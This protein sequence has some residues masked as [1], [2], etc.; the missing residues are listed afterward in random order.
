M[1]VSSSIGYRSGFLNLPPR[2]QLRMIDSMM[3]S[4]PT[5]ART[6]DQNYSGVFPIHFDDTTTLIFSGSDSRSLSRGDV[7]DYNVVYP[8][9]TPAHYPFSA[10][11]NN[12]LGTSLMVATP[13]VTSSISLTRGLVSGISEQLV[14][15]NTDNT[16]SQAL[17]PFVDSRVYLGDESFYLTG[18]DSTIL[19]GFSSRLANKIQI[20]INLDPAEETSVFFST[21]TAPNAVGIQQGVNSGLAYFN[22]NV[23]R[24]EVIGDLTTGSNVDY[25]NRRQSLRT[26]SY[27]AFP[28]GMA[29]NQFTQGLM[30]AV[31]GVS[32]APSNVAGFP[33]SSKFDATGSQLLRMSNYINH[34]FLMEKAV[35][36]WTGS[37]NMSSSGDPTTFPQVSSFFILNQFGTPVDR[38][39]YTGK[40]YYAEIEGGLH[41]VVG[42]NGPF[43]VSREKDLVAYG[44]IVKSELPAAE[45]AQNQKRDLVLFGTNAGVTGTFRLPM[46]ASVPGIYPHALMGT[47]TRDRTFGGTAKYDVTFLEIRMG[48]EIFLVNL[49]VEVS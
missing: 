43:S 45:M 21:G 1:P 33:L 9:L 4:Y 14:F 32:G 22:W 5:I 26:G 12:A 11:V 7:S 39:V 34:P 19:P 44:T 2:V 10:S 25:I 40:Q 18:T 29:G 49:P 13:N 17:N 20:T 42:N 41:Y 16:G 27:V 31:G 8:T 46:S 28:N 24:W 47:F 6:G 15:F 3:G 35:F 36:E 48:E 23:K 38:T 30:K 37:M